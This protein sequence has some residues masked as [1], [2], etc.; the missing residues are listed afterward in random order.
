MLIANDEVRDYG[1]AEKAEALGEKWEG[2]G[3]HVISMRDDFAT[4]YGEGV[5]K[6]DTFRWTEELAD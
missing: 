2:Y 6:T 4:I 1:N 5:E 3:F